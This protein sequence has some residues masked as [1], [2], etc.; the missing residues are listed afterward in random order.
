MKSKKLLLIMCLLVAV[1]SISSVSAAEID[2]THNDT[3]ISS[4]ANPFALQAETDNGDELS[5]GMDDSDVMADAAEDDNDVLS[6]GEKTFRDLQVLIDDSEGE[7]TL[8]NNYKYQDGDNAEGITINKNLTI[9]GNGKIIDG[10][11]ASRIFKV[12]TDC[13]SLTLKNLT[14]ENGYAKSGAAIYFYGGNSDYYQELSC[15]DLSLN[16]VDFINN[17]AHYNKGGAIYWESSGN[18]DLD[19]CVFKDNRA[20][21]DNPIYR[22]SPVERSSQLQGI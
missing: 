6:D 15:S 7:I 12:T 17:Y 22:S 3:V 5:N 1:L 18:V 21:I 13:S 14:L 8:N 11:N 20:D 4:E 2:D 19:H 10:A 16:H 9:N